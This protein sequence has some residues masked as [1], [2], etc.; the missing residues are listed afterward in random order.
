MILVFPFCQP[1]RLFFSSAII[2]SQNPAIDI[3]SILLIAIIVP[4]LGNGL[5]F[6]FGKH[7]ARHW[8]KTHGH[9][10]F[11]P[12]KRI[13]QAEKFFEQY[14]DKTVFIAAMVTSVRAVSSVI[15]GSLDMHPAKFFTYHF[16]GVLIWACSV[17]GIGYFWGD[18]IWYILQTHWKIIF[19]L[20]GVLLLLKLYPKK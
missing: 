13:K 7:G 12:N 5:L 8:L 15:A 1:V 18:E 3:F 16:F 11:L 9:K 4:P 20:V 6:Y 19:T 10:I 17:V 2:A 14:G